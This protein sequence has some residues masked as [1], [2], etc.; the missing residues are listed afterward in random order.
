M[1]RVKNKFIAKLVAILMALVAMCNAYGATEVVDGITWTYTVSDGKATVGGNLD[2]VTPA[3]P[4]STSGAI[5]VPSKLGGYPVVGIGDYAFYGCDLLKNVT[6]P[7]TVTTIGESAFLCSSIESV[8]I[9]DSV[10]SIG[11]DAFQCCRNLKSI[12]IPSGITRIASG[13][14]CGCD[15]LESVTIPDGVTYIWDY[16]FSVCESLVNLTI[17]NS[18]THIDAAA[19]MSCRSLK[20]VI[21]PNN[22][23]SINN[24]VFYDCCSLESIL[25][26]NSVTNIGDFAFENCSSLESVTIPNSVTYIGSEAFAYCDSLLKIE[27]LGNAPK[28]EGSFKYVRPLCTAYVKRGSTGWGVD[29]PGA[30][31][32]ITINYFEGDDPALVEI[33]IPSAVSNL[34][35]TGSNQVGVIESKGYTLIGNTATDAGTYQAYAKLEEGYKWADGTDERKFITYSIA[36]AT[37]EWTTLPSISLQEWTVGETPG[38]ITQ[39]VAKFGTITIEIGELVDDGGMI[40]YPIESF[41]LPTEPN[42][43]RIR[44]SVEGTNNYTGLEDIYIVFEISKKEVVINA[45]LWQQSL[46]V[47]AGETVRFCYD[48]GAIDEFMWW[49]DWGWPYSAVVAKSD[50][51]F[52][53]ELKV[54]EVP[55]IGFFDWEVPLNASGVYYVGMIPKDALDE[56]WWDHSFICGFEVTVVPSDAT[57]YYLEIV[58]PIR[59]GAILGAESG[60]QPIDAELTLTRKVDEGYHAVGWRGDIMGL[61]QNG[62]SLEVIMDKPRKIWLAIEPNIYTIT[63]ANTRGVTNL[64]PVIYTIEDE[65]IFN[66]LPYIEGWK[67]TG[68][69]PAFIAKGSIGPQNVTAN[70]ERVSNF[71]TIGGV[72]TN[73]A[74]G[75]EVTFRAPEPWVDVTNGMQIAYLGTTF[76]APIVTNEFALVITNDIDF[77]WD[78]LTTNY[79]L[80]VDVLG[81]GIVLPTSGWYLSSSVVPLIATPDVGWY[82]AG[83]SG[84]VSTNSY[85]AEMS[86]FM[87]QPR[88]VKAVFEKCAHRVEYHIGDGVRIGGGE[89]IQYVNTSGLSLTPPTIKAPAGWVFTGWDKDSI[90]ITNDMDVVAGYRTITPDLHIDTIYVTNVVTS[91][92]KLDISWKISNMGN[93]SFRGKMTEKI[94]LV[95]VVDP[96]D[97]RV[98][99]SPTFEGAVERDGFMERN[100]SIDIPLKGWEGKWCVRI[101]TATNPTMQE[102]AA[103]NV[104]T[105]VE[106]V[107]I[108]AVPLPDLRVDA[109]SGDANLIP[110]ETATFSFVTTND[111]MATAYAPWIDRIHLESLDTGKSIKVGDISRTNNIDSVSAIKGVH[112]LLIP[113]LIP[114]AGSVRVK[115]VADV[116]DVVVESNDDDNVA[117]SVGTFSL[118]T[119]L[120][121]TA[122]STSVYENVSGSGVRFTLKRSGPTTE[123][124]TVAVAIAGSATVNCPGSVTIPAGSVSTVF[125]VKPID[126][127]TVDGPRTVMVSASAGDCRPASLAMTILDN[128]VPKLTVTLDKTSIREGDG[129]IL[130]TVTRELVTD[131]PLRVYLSGVSTSRCSYP[132]FVVIPAGEASVTF[133]I[134]VPNNATAQI[135]QDLTLRAS[136]SGYTS[137]AVTYTVEDDDVPGVTLSLTPEVVSEGAGAQAIFATLTR[138]DTNQIAQAVRVKLTASVANQLILPS[139]ITIPK[140]TMAVRFAI[141]VV[142]NAL[143]DGDRE[144]GINGAIVIE[145]CGCNGQPSNGDVIEALVG[146]IDNDGPSLALKADPATMKEGLDPSGYLILSHNSILTEDLTVSLWVD[147]A[148]EDEIAI[149]EAVTIPAGETSVRIPVATLDDGVEDGGQLVSVYVEEESDVFAPASTWVQ[150]SDQNLPDLTVAN[151][152]TVSSVVAMENFTVSF[153]VT[154]IGFMATSKAVPY[155]VHLVKGLN[156]NAISSATLVKS[157][158]LTGVIDVGDALYGTV[159]LTA[160]ELSGDYRVA[161]VADPDG[162]ISELD[163]VNN[164]GWSS[165]I[166]VTVAYTATAGVDKKIY[167]PGETVTI[168]GVVSRVDGTT[169]G[170]VQIDPYVIMSGMRRSLLTT[171]AADGSY[172]TMF[173]P[174]SGEAG[175]YEVGACYPGVNSKVAQD[176]FSILGMKRVSTENVIWDIALGDSETRTMTIQNRSAVPLTGLT[177][178]FTDVPEECDLTYSLPDTI[179][180]NGTATLSMTATADGLTEQ[181]DYCKFYA[182]VEAAEGVSLEFPLYFHSQAQSAFLRATP[183]RIDTTM[184]IGHTRYIEVTVVN[185]GKGDTGSVSVSVPEV[186][187][188]KIVSAAS[189]DNLASGESATVILAVS[190]TAEDGLAL[191]NPLSGGRMA[192]NCANGTGCSVPLKFTPVSEATGSI[193]VDCVDNNTYYLDSQPHLSNATV[194]VSNPYTGIIVATGK[195]GAD[196][197]WT[198]NNIPEG[199]YQLTITAPNHDSYATAVV[200]EPERDAKVTAFLQNKIVSISWDVVN[201]EIEDSYDIQLLLDYETQVY[202]PI[203]KVEMPS[204]MPILNKGESYAFQ[205]VIRNE[206]LIAA[207]S[208][209]VTMPAIK[210]YTFS[211]LDNDIPISAKSSTTIAAVFTRDIDPIPVLRSANERRLSV[212]SHSGV[213]LLAANDDDDLVIC[214]HAV[215]VTVRYPCGPTVVEYQFQMVLRHGD[216]NYAHEAMARALYENFTL[217]WLGG[218]GGGGNGGSGGGTPS[219]G[220]D[221]TSISTNNF[222]QALWGGSPDGDDCD[223]CIDALLQARERLNL[224]IGETLW[225]GGRDFAMGKLVPFMSC[226]DLVVNSAMTVLPS[227]KNVVDKASSLP[228]IDIVL[229]D[230]FQSYADRRSTAHAM[231]SFGVDFLSCGADVLAAL[232]AGASGGVGGV[233]T[234]GASTSF[235][236][237]L[238]GLKDGMGVVSDIWQLYQTSESLAVDVILAHLDPNSEMAHKI[239]MNCE[240]NPTLTNA[241]ANVIRDV[242]VIEFDIHN[243]TNIIHGFLGSLADSNYDIEKLFSIMQTLLVNLNEDDLTV[244]K[245]TFVEMAAGDIPEDELR[246]YADEWN[247]AI[248]HWLKS[249]S[250]GAGT[251]DIYSAVKGIVCHSMVNNYVSNRGYNSWGEMLEHDIR[252]LNEILDNSGD[253][254]CA[255]ISLKLSQSVAMTREVFDGTLTLHN[256]NIKIPITDLKLNVSVLDEDG[257]ECKD[258]FEIFANGTSG[259]MSEG[260]V[261]EGG[262][263]VSADGTGFAMVRFVPKRAAAPTEER[264]YRFGGTVTYTEPFRSETITVRLMPVSLMVRPSPYLHLDYFVQRDVYADDPFT[265]NIVEASM[266]AELAVLVRNIG[267]GNANK[268]AIA[269]AQPEIVQN[270]KGLSVAFNLKDYMLEASALNGV[271]AHLGLNTVSL[272]MIEP[273]ESKVAQWWLTSSIE[274]HFIGMSA[275]VTPVNSWNTPDTA[276]VDPN[277]AVHKLV[278]SIVADGDTLPDFLVCDGSD[279]YGTPNEIYTAVGDQLP[280]YVASVASSATLTAGGEITLPLM[281]TPSRSGWNYGY[282][283]IPGIFRYTVSRILRSDGSEISLRNAWITDRTF[284]DGSTPLLEDRLHIVDEFTSNDKQ[285]YMVYLSAKPSD[286]PEVVA[287]E[288]VTGGAIEYITHDAITVKFSKPI[289]SATFTV[290]DLMLMKQ[291]SYI[292]DLSGLAITPADDSGTSFTIGN[293]SALCSEYGR[294]ELTVQCAG[295]ADT[296]GQLGSVGKSVSWT[297]ATAEA[298]YVIGVDGVPVRRVQSLDT[299]SVTFSAPIKL[300]TF[301]SAALR[302]NGV[303]VG[304]GVT[305]AALDASGTRFSVSGLSS[306]QTADGEYTLAVDATA[307]VGLN[308]THGVNTYTA[309]W[310]RDTVAPVLQSLT[311]TEGLNGSEFTLAFSEEVESESLTLHGA[312]IKRNG[313]S[314]ALPVSASLQRVADNAPY[315]WVLSGVDSVLSEDGAYELTFSANGVTDEAG[316]V[317]SGTK[318]MSWTVNRT[319]PAQISDLIVSPDGGFSD[320]DGVTYTGALT[321]SGTL[322]ED[323][324]TV[325]IIAK[326]IG[327]GEIVLMTLPS[328]GDTV[329]P[330]GAFSQNITLPGMGNVTLV[331]RLMNKAGYTSDTE[332]SIY[333]DGIALTGMLTGASED[334]GV[335]TS[336]AVLTFSDRVIDSDVTVDR[337]SLTRNG[338]AIALEGVSLVKE[339]ETTFRFLGLDGLCSEDGMYVLR[340]DGSNIQ[341]YTSGLT[342]IGSLVMRWSY[343]HPDREPPTVTEVLFDGETPHEAYTNV[344]SSVSVAFSEAVNVPELIDN[345]L[346]GVA[347]RIDLLDVTGTVIGCVSAVRRDGDVSPYQW[348]EKANTLSWQINPQTVPAGGARLVVDSTLVKDMADNRLVPMEMQQFVLGAKKYEA[349]GFM[350]NAAYSYACPTL[351][352][353]NGDGLLDLI[354]GEKTADNKGKVRIYLNRGTSASPLFDNWTYLQKSGSD[355]EFTAQGC[356]GMQVSFGNVGGATMV[357]AASPGEV[358]GW[359]HL[360]PNTADFVRWFDHSTDSCFSSLIRTQ[361]F[362]CDVDGDGTEEVLVSGQNSP[363]FWLKRIGFGENAVTECMPLVDSDGLYLRFPEGQNHTSAVMADMNGDFALDLVTGDSTGNVWVYF[364]VG[365][366]KFASKP[367]MVYKNTKTELKRS[368]LAI[369]DL[370]GDGVDDILVGRSDGSIIMLIGSEMPSPIVPFTV[371]AVVSASAGIHGAIAPNGDVTYDGGDTPEYTIMPDIGYYIADVQI[372]GASIGVTNNYVFAPLTTSHTIHADFAATAYPITYTGLKGVPNSNPVTYTV[373][374]EVVFAPLSDVEGWNFVGWSPKSIAKGSTGAITVT[375]QWE[376]VLH[377]VNVGGASMNVVYGSEMTFRAPEP[378]Y[379]ETCTT[380]IVYLGTTFTAPVVTNEFT[381]T[382]TNDIDFTWD[383][384]ATN[385]W[386]EVAEVQNGM[387]DAPENGWKSYGD[388]FVLSPIPDEHYHFV[389]WLGDTQGCIETNITDLVVTMDQARKISAAFAI[390]TFVV[391]F[392]PGAHGILSGETTQKLAYGATAVVPSVIPDTGYSF[393]G[394]SGDVTEPVVND[395]TFIAE[396]A[397][398][399]YDISYVELKGAE[400][401][402]LVAYTV[403]DEVV[404]APL[405]DVEGWNF[406]GWNPASIAKGSTG[407][408][409]VTAQ[410][411]RVIHSV[412]VGGASTNVV[413]GSEMTFRAPE[414]WYD[415]TCTT[416]IVYLGTTYTAPVVTNEFTVVVT[417]DIDFTWDILA[418]NHWL[419][420]NAS[421]GGSVDFDSAWMSAGSRKSISATSDFSYRFVRWEGDVSDSQSTSPDIVILMNQARS[422][423]AVFE[424]IPL[425]IGEAANAPE[426]E[427]YTEGDAVWFGEWSKAASDGVHAVRSGA[428]GD[429]EETV[430]GLRLEGAGTLSFDWRASSEERYDAVRLEVDGRQI[431][432]LSGETSWTNVCINLD[433]GEHNIRWIYKKGRSEASGEDAVWVDNVAWTS[434]KEPTL[435]EALGE[436]EW[437]TEGDVSWVGVRSECAYEGSSFAISEGLGDYGVSIIRARVLGAGIIKFRWAVSCEELYDW[438]DFIVDGE[439]VEMMTGETDWMEVTVELGEGDHV[440]EW[441]YWKDE[442]DDPDLVGANCAML[443]YVRWYP[444]VETPPEISD[445][446]LAAFF[447]WLKENNQISQNATKEDVIRVFSSGMTAVGK[448]ATLYSEFVAGT[449]PADVTSEFKVMIEVDENDQPIV[450]PSPNLGSLRKYVVFGKKNIE[451][452]TE[453]WKEVE[454]GKEKE[455]NFFKITVELPE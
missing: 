7:N 32:G 176:S 6:I 437:E 43:Y 401:P 187:W 387:I 177:I 369:G 123:A 329:L 419:K 439:V 261:L 60:P 95:S 449:N 107:K 273:N 331:V 305:I 367:L 275:T 392:D 256:G 152:E 365:N 268:V 406:V 231:V 28:C 383:I 93:S 181:V 377:S 40:F 172:C 112:S 245:E 347:T 249:P 274:G 286:V 2:E 296:V 348:N 335:L 46:T 299:I 277:V 328:G 284:R 416:Q 192:I 218:G 346:I 375:A 68:W 447:A 351:Y 246:Q 206:G 55:Y 413:Y 106:T 148:N 18:V 185:D 186:N 253:S 117:Y 257:N 130:A 39:P 168:T 327:G 47:K 235:K 171:T 429:S 197:I 154:N 103:N 230:H 298:P 342:M 455:Y 364:G 341:K 205:I 385:Y 289:D 209:R 217:P 174:T 444:L 77:T 149:P 336:S 134:S 450:T 156:V 236:I 169:A 138:S 315:Q 52:Y 212:Q 97:V 191:N 422:L 280:V 409:T 120:Y 221:T 3:V 115:A 85:Q 319:P 270:E 445:K 133:E 393:I 452:S 45:D 1:W 122:V 36:K 239:R 96:N 404:F 225:K 125:Y 360:E 79:W 81:S 431:R 443:D 318:T 90:C 448:S 15:S 324:L 196:G 146:I 182:Q 267:G 193:T 94:E 378:W 266:P 233:A 83:W 166:G 428:I 252:N 397:A 113:E 111:G 313:A 400:N 307:V 260:S 402:N 297:Y 224:D 423:K 248:S 379:D 24:E 325:E 251:I 216:C 355:V 29:I 200:I 163:S 194:R 453:G 354:V 71:V 372:D 339:S 410:W 82:F 84:N 157:G 316:N 124:M 69:S 151:I 30:W 201:A 143:D 312:T 302:M 208:V 132:S 366:A 159:T 322:P 380:Q 314:V 356:V 258:M 403:E 202:A 67:F 304:S 161:I 265:T 114:L 345:G 370:N 228:M 259:D 357:L 190:P 281:L 368:R 145:S 263:S 269:S 80:G 199:T 100:I 330:A 215:P 188:L 31:N 446:T 282:A 317:A 420:V 333:V 207:D 8:V 390:D 101:E 255:G 87:T 435:A 283:T 74:Y 301:T 210:G 129:V 334:E 337:F 131:E 288:G 295:I 343:K 78:I 104:T 226:V 451:D 144:I 127:A 38:V 320:T 411:K 417:N 88:M 279:L 153:A 264:L 33:P 64:N 388:T 308:D 180:A 147:D 41:I 285:T 56:G 162:T 175:D 238:N 158:I 309:T 42:I 99:A 425:T 310:M 184:A 247:N 204:E 170:N 321:V 72:S 408:I 167:L 424:K 89:L 303:A 394:W 371:K 442:M 362:C 382:V 92:E 119:N 26:P 128:E 415:E 61:Y 213:N 412:N 436:F 16:A 211:L 396:Y 58:Q 140:Y 109:V 73:I 165:V 121:L 25:I 49:Y 414:P 237:Y 142:D 374:D 291:G 62:D 227:V 195:T 10:R 5:I 139:E 50:S 9:P 135:A 91:G 66:P 59:G 35:Y 20:S 389:S 430:L 352:D 353:W 278:R 254:V 340:F 164:K 223:P 232:G 300:E 240:S 51:M 23:A 53:E 338:M 189:I 86:I 242:A 432:V 421:E 243:V 12:R 344:F 63:Y 110:G 19:F 373:E 126:N 48:L 75:T 116:N 361:T 391:T 332:K 136:S 214:W 262:L 290:D 229:E 37:N 105:T 427:W 219:R 381:V 418:T 70:W 98:I 441:M 454:K 141:G 102:Y 292:D 17:P 433:I 22:I 287:F 434:A 108:T 306:A 34:V 179:P 386:F 4:V 384:L 271:T 11:A 294:Y 407:A 21:L 438:L 323:G 44:Y 118:A 222:Y 183:T 376:R 160:P 359:N 350:D 405:S 57:T 27:F 155:A 244:D 399:S 13:T 395:V 203:V 358:Y 250:K 241:V 440:L 311:H 326:Y 54:D 426:Y 178:T 65:V 220:D 398:I 137:T 198:T 349:V 293:L 150:I 234:F 14:F 363:M 272:G 173:T 76:T 276:L